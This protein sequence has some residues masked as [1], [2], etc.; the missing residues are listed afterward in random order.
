VWARGAGRGVR[1]LCFMR[2]QGCLYTP[3]RWVC[4]G[5]A[6]MAEVVHGFV[7]GFECSLECPVTSFAL[8]LLIL[9]QA[10]TLCS[11]LR[12]PGRGAFESKRVPPRGSGTT[13]EE[14]SLKGTMPNVGRVFTVFGTPHAGTSQ[15]RVSDQSQSSTLHQAA[16]QWA[17]AS[18]SA[19]TIAE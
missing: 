14:S 10:D 6:T 4:V 8:A 18:L 11:Y 17:P 5:K 7:T 12:N 13:T 15:I 2:F 1:D 3:G 16:P 9:V 19:E